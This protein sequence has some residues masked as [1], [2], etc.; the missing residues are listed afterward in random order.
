[1][2]K[3]TFRAV[4]AT[5]GTLT[6]LVTLFGPFGGNVFSTLTA[7]AEERPKTVTGTITYVG[8][9]TPVVGANVNVWPFQNG[10][11]GGS[12]TT[13][14]SGVYTVTLMQTTSKYGMNLYAT[15]NVDWTYNQPPVEIQFANDSTL[16]TQ[17]VN[18]QVTKAT[19][20]ITGTVTKDGAP[21]MEGNIN[22]WSTNGPGGGGNAQVSNGGYT[23]RVPAGSFSVGFWSP[24][25]TL[26]AMQAAVVIADGQTVTQNFVV[27]A[28]TAH[29]TGRLIDGSGTPI[30][31]VRMNGFC[32][33]PGTAG[34]QNGPQP[35]VNG[36]GTS[37]ADGTFDLAVLAGRCN[38]NVDNWQDPS[39][40][41]PGPSYVYNGKP[42]ETTLDTDTSSF[43]FGDVTVVKADATIIVNVVKEDGTPATGL[44]GYVYAQKAGE[45]QFGPGQN[46]GGS[47]MPDGKATIKMPSSVFSLVKLGMHLPPEAEY[48][49]V[50]NTTV[51]VVANS[52]ST[53]TLRVQ[54]NNSSIYGALVDQNGI[55]L[56][57]C[58]PPAGQFS[59]GDVFV[60][61][62]EKGGRGVQFK[63]DCSYK[64]SVVAGTYQF[65]YHFNDGTG[66]LNA[67]QGQDKVEVHT[68]ENLVKNIKALVGDAKINITVVDPTGAPV[69]TFVD[70]GNEIELFGKPGGPG[71]PGNEGPKDLGGAQFKDKNGNA[72]DPFEVCMKA[73]QKKDAAQIK[74][75]EAMKLPNISAGPGGCKNVGACVK[76]CMVPA[77]Q[78]ECGKFKGP[79][80]SGSN[81]GPQSGPGGC[82][83]DAECK[84]FCSKPENQ[85]TC[86]NFGPPPGSEGGGL[87]GA[88]FFKGSVK[89]TSTDTGERA[90]GGGPRPEDFKN[91]LH[92]GTMTSAKGTASL[93]MLSGHLYEVHVNPPPGSPWMPAQSQ[94][95]DFRGSAR[96][97]NLT[98]ALRQAD[99][100]ITGKVVGGGQFGFCHG[101]EESGN[102]SGGQ[103]QGGKFE[104][105]VAK[106]VW[107]I[108][109]DA[110]SGNDFFR[111]E[112]V[113][114]VVDGTQKTITQ[115]FVLS[116]NSNFRIPNPV[117]QTTDA[118][119]AFSMTLE[120][121]TTV[122]AG[123]SAF[124]TSGNVTI[125]ATPT[126]NLMSQ[127][128]AKPAWYGYDFKALNASTGA[129]IT[130]FNSNVT[131]TF[132]YTDKML[133]A[134]GVD[135]SA[136]LPRYFDDSTNSWK[137]P[138][139]ATQDT[140]NNTLTVTS[141]HFSKWSPTSNGKSKS[142]TAV[143]V[144]TGKNKGTFT[145]GSGKTAKKVTAFSGIGLNVATAN[146]GGS[147]GQ[148]I[149]AAPSENLKTGTSSV[150]VYTTKGKL[151]KTLTPYS[152]NKAISLLLADITK[153]GKSDVVTSQSA[154]K[155]K[156]FVYDAAKKY[157]SYSVDSGAQYNSTVKVT[158][159]EAQQAGVSS[160]TVLTQTRSKNSVKVYSFS[161][162]ALKAT[163]LN[164]SSSRLK[165]AGTS[166]SLVIL[167]PT[168][169]ITAGKLATTSATAKL[170]IKG[171][172]FV[173]GAVAT[174]SGTTTSVRFVNSTQIVVTVD[175]TALTK[176]K[177]YTL[178][179]VNPDGGTGT[180]KVK[181]T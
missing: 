78:G 102:F 28:K 90:Q 173:K 155:A 74:K 62:T 122:V 50:E 123:A 66:L 84:T 105:N 150:K 54:K 37:G 13:N 131:I 135:E 107:H 130:S 116:K 17:T 52:T 12:G 65:N 14:S 162:G 145:I 19:A 55:P 81:S 25:Q 56:S 99:A 160:L 5:L 95:V 23:L 22:A 87:T 132:K 21:V 73:Y 93:S 117:S 158:T 127:S 38:V 141:D 129:E 1:M 70:A 77:N 140:D 124:A 149:F 106:G 42:L 128:D 110:P 76:F 98:F 147:T 63:S 40:P 144:G 57:S 146:L 180:L 172:N 51:S 53:A 91:V 9:S 100:K 156:V 86:Q 31:G 45:E 119:Q 178:K 101:W 2:R 27:K 97:A 80:K 72:G 121:G 133:E 69:Q 83:T 114:I 113:T 32:M 175:G 7:R 177:T 171:S 43:A 58:T 152:G 157:K 136:L 153:D 35:G 44:N 109:C 82:K 36:N 166:V 68:G 170:T 67:N 143:T 138:S 71:G 16:E 94:T 79:E 92:S 142:T 20:T 115:N 48:S 174:I 159:L 164:E 26:T 126:A 4:R 29:L 64:V 168:G 104:I 181:A 11:G 61:S 154:S 39:N 161:K 10:F 176:G 15:S 33:A 41:S 18:F 60:N 3:T 85:K 139:N 137:T 179:I 24:D 49:V 96:S 88:S 120:D 118:T 125:T 34:V 103:A 134:A 89:G 46:F 167:K 108:G 163:S 169:A 75:C 47:L 6:V 8:T 112:E 165:I 30:A 148:L 111:S 151:V 59:F